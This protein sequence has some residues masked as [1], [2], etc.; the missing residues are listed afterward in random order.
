VVAVRELGGDPPVSHWLTASRFSQPYSALLV[1]LDTTTAGYKPGKPLDEL[2]R[3]T[4][5]MVEKLKEL[6]QKADSERSLD[7]DAYNSLVPTYNAQLRRTKQLWKRFHFQATALDD[8]DL[9]FNRCIDPAILMSKFDEIDL[10]SATRGRS[11]VPS[12]APIDSA[13]H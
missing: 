3:N 1:K 11:R 2:Q 10:T 6:R 5:A 8:L 4:V 12:D 13:Q 9:A 7:P